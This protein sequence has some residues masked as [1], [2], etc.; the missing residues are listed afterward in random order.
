[1]KA[2]ARIAG[3]LL[4]AAALACRGG[5]ARPSPL[6]TRNDLCSSCR[7]PVSNPKLAAQL[8]APGE[9]PRFFDDV[10]CLRDYLARGATPPPGSIAYVADHRT[11]EW[12]PA[13]AAL[14]SRCPS[15]ETPMASHIVAHAN[16]ASRASD[17]SASGCAP[18]TPVELFGPPG[19]PAGKKAG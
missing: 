15:V 1:M 11:G 5:A 14:F 19:P 13:S 16:E 18:L 12:A 7:M 8:A 17:P 9:E 3:I 2:V 6:D 10:G 4:A